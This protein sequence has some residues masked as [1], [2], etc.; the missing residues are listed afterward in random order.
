MILGIA[1]LLCCCSE[2]QVQ[3]KNNSSVPLEDVA[4][5]AGERSGE[6]VKRIEPFAEGKTTICPRGEAGTFALSFKANGQIYRS[7]HG[8]YFECNPTYRISI[9]VSPKFDATAGLIFR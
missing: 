1:M 9:E 4:I 7:Q 8:L 2:A 5:T 3:I 6:V